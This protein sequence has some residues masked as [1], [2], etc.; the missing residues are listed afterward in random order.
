MLSCIKVLKQCNTTKN[1]TSDE[2]Q[3]TLTVSSKWTRHMIDQHKTAENIDS[4]AFILPPWPIYVK[5][6]VNKSCFFF[7]CTDCSSLDIVVEIYFMAQK[8]HTVR[9][10]ELAITFSKTTVLS[11]FFHHSNNEWHLV[12]ETCDES[13][14][15]RVCTSHERWQEWCTPPPPWRPQ[16]D[17]WRSGW[18]G[19]LVS[20]HREP[21]RW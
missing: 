4:Y 17:P 20:G 15:I 21:P 3:N 14:I 2:G 19:T 12:T 10:G 8:A 6:H 13:Q 18:G 1:W 11:F 7:S 16:T 9:R 5:N